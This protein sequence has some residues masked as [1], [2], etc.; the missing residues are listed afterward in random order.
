MWFVS[1]FEKQQKSYLVFGLFLLGFFGYKGGNLIQTIVNMAP[2]K[3]YVW[4]RD[5]ETREYNSY[6]I[7]GIEFYV[8]L[9]SGQIG[10]E[11]FPSA[12]HER[13]DVELRGE[14]LKEG[15]RRISH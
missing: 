11:K 5:Y 7:Q 2:Q 14:D 15:F 6:E 4:Q 3:Y 9:E 1:L 10:Y 13:Y 12:P 8:P